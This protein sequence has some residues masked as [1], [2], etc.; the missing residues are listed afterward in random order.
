L[1]TSGGQRQLAPTS[2]HHLPTQGNAGERVK[3]DS[4]CRDQSGLIPWLT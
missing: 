2:Y 3:S 4:W 1:G